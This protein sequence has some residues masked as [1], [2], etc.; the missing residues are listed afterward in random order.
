VSPAVEPEP[1]VE[2]HPVEYPNGFT[3]GTI[4]PLGSVEVCEVIGSSVI[5]VYEVRVSGSPDTFDVT[6]SQIDSMLEYLELM[7]IPQP[8]KPQ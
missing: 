3:F 7:G 1:I 6:A 2:E 4:G 5:R 8:D